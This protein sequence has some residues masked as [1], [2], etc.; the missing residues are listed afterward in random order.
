MSA[1]ADPKFVPAA[2]TLAKVGMKVS[3]I[4]S[5]D[6]LISFVLNGQ[7][8]RALSEAQEAVAVYVAR[9][10]GHEFDWILTNLHISES[11]AKRREIEGMALLRLQVDEADV[12]R[13]QSAIR[14]GG[15]GIKVVDEITAKSYSLDDEGTDARLMD[16]EVLSAG[17]I[18][19]DKFVTAE[20]G[21]ALSDKQAAEIV[22]H[23]RKVVVDKVEPM[24]AATIVGAVPTFAEGAGLK[25]KEVKRTTG[26]G[27]Q[28]GP[29]TVEFH[30]KAA[31]RDVAALE[32]AADGQVYELTVHDYKAIFDLCS[33]FGLSLEP[34]EALVAA[35]D[36]AEK[37]GL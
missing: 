26:G 23:A 10:R 12:P 24:N 31:L 18:I 32:K 17:K 5:D 36:T 13:V 1:A 21:M 28:S 8:S 15:L 33:R 20:K 27:A 37:A 6:A 4:R 34:T 29:Q 3:D 14:T 11:T 30:I 16:L 19:K 25:I 22:A 7:K 35:L 9:K 2:A